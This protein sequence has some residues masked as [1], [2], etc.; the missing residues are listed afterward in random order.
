[1]ETT[2]KFDL[3]KNIID[4]NINSLNVTM[5][6]LK[7]DIHQYFME[8]LKINGELFNKPHKIIADMFKYP[9]YMVGMFDS[10]KDLDADGDSDEV[11]IFIKF[12]E[13][14]WLDENIN[15]ENKDEAIM[16]DYE[17]IPLSEM[18]IEA[19]IAIYEFIKTL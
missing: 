9:I 13:E 1:M 11:M 17:I 14:G 5:D 18:N 3:I 8:F 10:A 6:M 19:Q 12:F 2:E 16:S 7:R 15:Y 4:N